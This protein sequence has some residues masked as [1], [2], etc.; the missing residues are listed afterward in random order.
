M[1]Q[2]SLSNLSSQTVSALRFPLMVCVVF[3]HFSVSDGFTLQGAD[4]GTDIPYW[5]T[6]VTYFFSHVLGHL[7]VP[8]FFIFSGY[9]FFYSG[10]SHD[11]YKSKLKKRARTLLIPYILWNLIA[12]GY[13]AVRT[14]PTLHWLFPNAKPLEWSV[15]GFLG[16]FWDQRYNMFF[17]PT[18]HLEDTLAGH[19][20]DYPL[21]YVRDLMIVALFSP[22]IYWAIKKAG[23]YIVMLFG[24]LWYVSEP[25]LD[26]SHLCYTLKAIFFFSWGACYAI[27]G[28]DFVASM[29]QFK[30]APY[31]FLAVGLADTLTQDIIDPIYL[32]SLGRIL[33]P[34]TAVS[35]MAAL[36]ERGDVRIPKA[37]SESNFVIFAFHSLIIGDVMK[38]IMKVVFIDSAW[39][40]TVSYFLVPVL[41]ILI[42]VAIYHIL[43]LFTPHLCALLT[44]GR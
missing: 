28:L 42:C 38:V 15:G 17:D 8:A 16:C 14:L 32:N 29:R 1:V 18:E 26:S 21:W 24:L 19:P 33:A 41:T 11:A 44:G 37:L 13:Y 3:A 40:L 7:A 6:A 27:K 9:F 10:F 25:L 35:V 36:I 43:H 30:I 12:I 34:F 20:L 2:K 31:L 4:Y 23:W 5:L 22:L 39:F